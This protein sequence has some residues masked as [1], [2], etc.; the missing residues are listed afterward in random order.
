MAEDA[1]AVASSGAENVRTITVDPP[2]AGTESHQQ[3][4]T[5]G[6]SQGAVNGDEATGTLA[7][8]NAEVAIA[9]PALAAS[10]S[11]DIQGTWTAGT[12]VAIEG[13]LN[14]TNWSGLIVRELGGNN[15][16]AGDG[17]LTSAVA[18]RTLYA[19]VG[20]LSQVRAR[21]HARAGTDSLTVMLKPGADR[22]PLLA[23]AVGTGAS[24]VFLPGISTRPLWPTVTKGTQV[25][26]PGFN[27]QLLSDT[28]RVMQSIQLSETAATTEAM[29]TTSRSVGGAA[30]STGTSWTVTSGK[31][32]RLTGWS[33]GYNHTAV[34]WYKAFLRWTNTGAAATSSPFILLGAV[35][36]QA[37]QGAGS[38]SGLFPDGFD[39][40]GTQQFGISTIGA[41]AAGTGT[42]SVYGFE[43]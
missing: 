12:Q 32:L 31:I 22:N 40:S 42:V 2:G 26:D 9:V 20:G 18:V 17:L 30:V 34:G 27:V 33:I 7:A 37:T 38:L 16:S 1:I 28:G 23:V 41:L 4:V 14:D 24:N 10:V 8:V 36:N 6:D 29:R 39:L 21:M 43:Y 15:I 19:Q 11:I 13:T 3:V 5:L 25:T 35:Q